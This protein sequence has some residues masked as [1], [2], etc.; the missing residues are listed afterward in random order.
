M[1]SEKREKDFY[2]LSPEETLKELNS[3]QEGLSSDELQERIEKFGKNELP[4]GKKRSALKIFFRQLASPLV[5]V[6]LMAMFFSFLIGH[7]ADAMFIVF[8]IVVNTIVGFVQE[9]KSEKALEKLNKSVRFYCRVFRD[10]RKFRIQSEELVVGDIVEI[11]SGDKIPADGRLIKCYGLKVNEA[12]LTGEWMPIEKDIEIIHKKSG[13]SDRKNMVFMGS[14]VDDGQ[15]LFVVTKVGVKTE[16]GNISKLVSEEKDVRT[17]LQKKFYELSQK[18]LVLILLAVFVFATIYVLRGES[19][20]NV[21][22]TSIAL[23]VSAVPEGLL[24][25]ITIV[26]VLAMRRLSQKKALVRKL[27][28]TEGMGSISVICMDKTG[29]LTLG[30]MRISHIITGTEE[31]L[32]EAGELDEI[33]DPN[34]ARAHLKALEVATMVNEAYIENPDDE[35]SEYIIRGRHTDK[36]LLLAGIN[37]GIIREK[38][39]RRYPVIQNIPFNSLNKFAVKVC[40]YDGGV[41]VYALG[42]PEAII[43]KSKNISVDEK[44][45]EEISSENAQ[46]LFQRVDELSNQGLRLL[47]CAWKKMS[48]EEYEKI[49]DNQIALTTNL[50]LIGFIALKDPLRKDAKESVEKAQRAG[51]RPILITGDHKNTAKAIISELGIKVSDKE[52]L[53]GKDLD[54][55]DDQALLRKVKTVSIFARVVPEHKIR[56]VKALQGNGEVVA[57][58]GDGVNDAPA[59]KAADIGVSVENGTDIAKEVSDIVLLDDNFSVIIK[60]IEQG[61]LAKDNIRRIIVYLL[62][63]DF[64]EL[65]LFFA[66]VI[67]G[68]PFPLYPAQILWINLVEDGFPDMAL[69]TESDTSGIMDRKPENPKDPLLSRSYKKFMFLV[70][71]ISGLSACAIFCYIGSY[72]GDIE[73][74]RTMTFALIAFDSLLFAYV[75][76]SFRKS[77]FSKE[78]FSNKVLNW[79]ILASILMLLLGMYVP[80]FQGFLR[81]QNIEIYDWAII[82]GITIVETI[83]FDFYKMRLF[84]RDK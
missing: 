41:V 39:E 4:Q 64:S 54:E 46:R 76:K 56:I 35:I 23:V 34:S 15:G 80:F 53:E 44:G 45:E 20:Y 68:M 30:K 77:F 3:K 61:R 67:L 8:V 27:D 40:Q 43:E 22:I 11:S 63:D 79:A 57:M 83:I 16:L 29:T 71:L 14:I 52:I 21:F 59:L 84:G 5:V 36:A 48:V 73:K 13:V 69:T 66:A 50:D 2:N 51:I 10:G 55:M 7:V 17:P 47:S 74:A 32:K 58:V 1:T 31:L 42:S 28:A 19:L 75:V 49:K 81:V 82:I 33:Y 9:A 37:A 62:A 70:F 6:V 26:L 38:L 24:P 78:N 25:A 12:A 18:M 65:F 72:L 60:A